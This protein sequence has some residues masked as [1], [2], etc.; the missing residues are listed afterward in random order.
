MNIPTAGDGDIEGR[1]VDL[2]DNVIKVKDSAT[3]G[4]PEIEAVIKKLLNTAIEYAD[5]NGL[6]YADV[7]NKF[8]EQRTNNRIDV[9]KTFAH[10]SSYGIKSLVF[11]IDGK[12]YFV[13]YSSTIQ[14]PSEKIKEEFKNFI[15]KNYNIKISKM[16]SL[17]GG[18]VNSEIFLVTAK[19]G[20]QYVFKYLS[21]EMA[22]A[23]YI[24]DIQAALSRK[25]LPVPIIYANKQGGNVTERNAKYYS[26]EDFISSGEEISYLDLTQAHHNSLAEFAAQMHNALAS[27]SIENPGQV[28]RLYDRI[29]NAEN[30][31]KKHIA[32]IPERSN[33][34]A[35]IFSLKHKA[36]LFEQIEKFK[37]NYGAVEASLPQVDMNEDVSYRNAKYDK[38]GNVT[39]VFDFGFCQKNVRVLAFNDM[40]FT[41]VE[42]G[43]GSPYKYFNYYVVKNALKTYNDTLENK[44]SKEEIIAIVEI[45]RLRLIGNIVRNTLVNPSRLDNLYTNPRVIAF[46]EE[47]MRY[48]ERFVDDFGENGINS[49]IDEVLVGVSEKM[50]FHKIIESLESL[51]KTYDG[52]NINTDGVQAG[53]K[54]TTLAH[55][56]AN[57]LAD[58]ERE[59]LYPVI[60]EHNIGKHLE[61][62]LPSQSAYASLLR[63]S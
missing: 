3:N 47:N 6:A 46:A 1:L 35:D 34:P 20:K 55:N 40:F 41:M 10:T 24:T 5:K 16:A 2:I 45:L 9:R 56:F 26:L 60:E 49:L 62:S 32:G 51:S 28:N 30:A 17:S 61:P 25:G 42:G 58:A 54:P 18:S 19:S 57:S 44:L 63:A 21:D 7:L 22:Y 37:I 29:I 36:F 33:N 13:S 31:L 27:A 4:T 14:I 23:K 43:Y 53:F 11:T 15:E 12:T 59:S 38:N 8:F 52:L 48:F 50:G 39:A